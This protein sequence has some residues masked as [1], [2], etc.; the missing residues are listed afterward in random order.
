MGASARWPPATSLACLRVPP[1]T[2]SALK[3]PTH[4]AQAGWRPRGTP[5]SFTAKRGRKECAARPMMT[6]CSATARSSSPWPSGPRSPRP[7]APSASTEAPTTRGAG[8]SSATASRSS[9]PESAAGRRCQTRCRRWSR[10]ACSRLRSPTPALGP[11]GGLRARSRE[12]GRGLGLPRDGVARPAPPRALAPAGALLARGRL[13]RPL[14]PPREPEEE[15][16][17]EAQRPGELVGMDCFSSGALRA[18][19]ARSGS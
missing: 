14:K 15:R 11:G 7:A 4:P 2:A 16:H 5:S 10:S 8:A 9:R 6:A 3:G 19:R 13:L 17:V 12:V 18:Q 1:T